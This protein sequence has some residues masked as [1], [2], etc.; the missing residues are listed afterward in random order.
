MSH[1]SP[2]NPGGSF[3]RKSRNAKKL[4]GNATPYR[5]RSR[6]SGVGTSWPLGLG[7]RR[8]H[9]IRV[10]IADA[11]VVVAARGFDAGVVATSAL[12][13]ATQALTL[14]ATPASHAHAAPIPPPA[15][16]TRA[17]PGIPTARSPSTRSST[18]K[19]LKS[20]CRMLG[21]SSL[22][23]VCGSARSARRRRRWLQTVTVLDDPRLNQRLV[24]RPHLTDQVVRGH[25]PSLRKRRRLNQN[26]YPHREP[27]FSGGPV[28]GAPASPPSQTPRGLKTRTS[29]PPAT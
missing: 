25:H 9:S 7:S 1:A 11:P 29:A 2:S 16:A 3:V 28:V 14:P 10:K 13:L 5:S 26:H 17:P 22:C 6:C 20:Q 4:S 24:E 15:H 18:T 27:H 21:V 8:A 19:W 12:A 23:S